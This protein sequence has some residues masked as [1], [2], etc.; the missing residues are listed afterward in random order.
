MH[1]CCEG[2]GMTCSSA[3]SICF[4]FTNLITS[5][6]LADCLHIFSELELSSCI[7][8]GKTDQGKHRSRAPSSGHY[9]KHKGTYPSC[10]TAIHESL[11]ESIPIRVFL[12]NFL[13]PYYIIIEI[14]KRRACNMFSSVIWNA[15]PLRVCKWAVLYHLHFILSQKNPC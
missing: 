3:V 1:A 4:F 15:I 9:I 14:P 11:T 13:V 6:T 8:S 7:S 5:L 10:N 12:W 2:Y